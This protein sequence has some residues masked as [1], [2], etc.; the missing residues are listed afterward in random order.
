MVIILGVLIAGLA[1]V[2]ANLAVGARRSESAGRQ[3]SGV[4]YECEG[5]LELMR[6]EITRDYEASSLNPVLWLNNR[7]RPTNGAC[8]GRS[9]YRTYPSFPNVRAWIEAVSTAGNGNWIEIVAASNPAVGAGGDNRKPV[10]IRTRLVWGN[11]PIFDLALLS[12]TTKCMWCHVR[13][14]GDVGSIDT[15]DPSHHGNNNSQVEG[16]VYIAAGKNS[17]FVAGY[18]AG[19]LDVGATLNNSSRLEITGNLYQEYTGPKLPKDIDGDLKP[20]FPAIDP[21]QA[22]AAGAGGGFAFGGGGV[23][24][25]GNPSDPGAF[26]AWRVPLG[27]TSA[28]SGAAAPLTATQ[29]GAVIDGNLILI[30][31]DA[32]PIELNGDV[33]VK[34]DVVIRGP[35][36]GKGAIYSGRNLYMV[37]DVYLH[38]DAEPAN[39]PPLNDADAQN[40]MATEPNAGE[41]RLA[42]RSNVVVGD[43][44]YN[45]DAGTVNKVRERQGAEFMN[46][47]FDIHTGDRYF[48][49]DHTNTDSVGSELKRVGTGASTKFYNDQGLEVPLNQVTRV[50]QGSNLSGIFNETFRPEPYNALLAPGRVERDNA[51]PFD[52]ASPTDNSTF[53]PWMSQTEYR[54]ILGTK[55]YENMV[56]RAASMPA[57]AR[58]SELGSWWDSNWVG[59]QGRYVPSADTNF[60]SANGGAFPSGDARTGLFVRGSGGTGT[61]TAYVMEQGM[62]TFPTEVRR[63]DAFVYANKRVAGRSTFGLVVNG[64]IAA[65]HVGYLAPG[66]HH[67]TNN[68]NSSPGNRWLHNSSLVSGSPTGSASVLAWYN[69][70][71]N[72]GGNIG[73][74]VGTVSGTPQA[75]NAHGDRIDYSF[76]N[77]DYRLRNGGYGFNLVDGAAGDAFFNVREGKRTTTL[78]P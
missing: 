50:P 48:Q 66:T 8:P 37:G 3:S 26:G 64:G 51:S 65:E 77:Y 2:T 10:S 5:A 19:A 35:Y 69:D 70:G 60:S 14:K 54:A 75:F 34:G 55:Q 71:T 74:V 59:N 78:P 29:M 73:G 4:V 1:F 57:S 31:T 56:W 44:T 15:F 62:S 38:A 45:N 13:I 12:V 63:I 32:N 16:D 18:S 47:E 17:P 11:N 39:W 67:I 41:L 21:V 42:A 28:L 23:N 68:S 22:Q 7:V 24:T 40:T 58:G 9:T 43:W 61:G 72:D 36:K 27:S 46:S 53:K 6:L 76:I 30:G 49:V 25:S 52:P 33:Y 20:D